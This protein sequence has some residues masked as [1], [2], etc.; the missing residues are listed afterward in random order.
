MCMLS[1]MYSIYISGEE[2]Y[3]KKRYNAGNVYNSGMG[4][5]FVQR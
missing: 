1:H 5:F 4:M 2:K 3:T